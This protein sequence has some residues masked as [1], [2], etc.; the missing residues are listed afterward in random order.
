MERELGTPIERTCRFDE[1]VNAN[2]EKLTIL[3][4]LGSP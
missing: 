1:D 3:F 4:V 2:L